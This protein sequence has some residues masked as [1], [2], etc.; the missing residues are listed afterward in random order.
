MLAKLSLA[1][2][3]ANNGEEALALIEKQ[4]YDLVL[5][6]CQMPVMDGYQATAAVRARQ[7]GNAKRLP[8]IALTANA[9]EGDR[10]QCIKAGMDDY[11][12]KP[13]SRQQLEQVLSRWLQ[14]EHAPMSAGAEPASVAAAEPET[15]V[16]VRAASINRKFLDQLCELDPSGGMGLARQILQVYLDSTGK[17]V[18]QAEQAI[19]AGDA[20]ALRFAAHSL[21]SSSANV[22]AETLSGLFKQLEGLARES[23]LGDASALFDSAQREY[24][25]ARNEI[26]ALQAEAA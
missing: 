13:Y 18:S 17:L 2:D 7:A 22:G 14:A 3:V 5:M 20:E 21:K 9:M 4:T 19:A 15:P 25:L 12:A 10:E 24:E 16:P 11:L 8:I 26:R 1:V 23:N 6:D